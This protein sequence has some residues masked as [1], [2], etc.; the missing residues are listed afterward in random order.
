METPQYY[1]N[2]QGYILAFEEMK[3]LLAE[4][5]K[6]IELARTTTQQV[7]GAAGLIIGIIGILPISNPAF[8]T[9]RSA[10][11]LGLLGLAAL[12]YT[13][14]IILC[15][16][17][18]TLSKYYGPFQADFDKLYRDIVNHPN[19]NAMYKMMISIYIDTIEHNRPIMKFKVRIANLGLILLATIIGLIFVAGIV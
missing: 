13:A 11:S 16:L 1:E 19:D 14:L 7:L 4:Q 3:F 6:S 9:D 5:T 10:M 12:L 17:N 2:S 8:A 15:V 18:L